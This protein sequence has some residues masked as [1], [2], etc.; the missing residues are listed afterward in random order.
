MSNNVCM[1]LRNLLESSVQR[2]LSDAVLLSG[3]LDS[4]II[5]GIAAKVKRLTGITIAYGNAPDLKYAKSI[6]EKY[7]IKHI[8]KRLTIEDANDAIEN[9]VR[10]MKT[11]DPMEIRNTSVIYASLKEL[12]DN[13][14]DSAM[15]GDGGD[16][17]FVGYHYLQRLDSKEL[18]N[19]LEKLWQIMHFSSLAIGNEL[20]IDVKTPYLDKEFV[21]FAKQIPL[22]LKIKE[23]DGIRWGKWILRS[24]FEDLVSKEIAWRSKMPLEQGAGISAFAEN[25]NMIE[26]SDFTDRV[27]F[28]S[29]HDSVKIRDKE[30]LHYYTIYRKFFDAPKNENCDF[31]CPE[32]S[33]CV[34]NDSRF[35]RT[36][37]TFPI[38][39]L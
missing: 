33:G 21:E 3:G 28:Y 38:K 39:P 36:C 4:S 9:V 20:S 1:E 14:F 37:G 18:A 35:C 16:E 26:D 25:F 32:C 19:E 6:A 34:R 24:C 8:V 29:S 22:D 27:K 30:Q 5:V 7:S 31:R 13:G 11:F 12:K 15:T 2:N 23:K 10:V 17:L